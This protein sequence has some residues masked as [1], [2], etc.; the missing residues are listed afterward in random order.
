MF[1]MPLMPLCHLVLNI[2]YIH[3]GINSGINGKES[4]TAKH[5]SEY[6]YYLMLRSDC[7][8]L[9][10]GSPQLGLFGPACELHA[11]DCIYAIL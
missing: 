11:G 7:L 2:K 8:S 3:S 6:A 5:H 1:F 9:F 10:V 4:Q